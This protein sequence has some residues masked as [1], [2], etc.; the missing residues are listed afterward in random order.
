MSLLCQL[1]LHR[2]RAHST[3]L[4]LPLRFERCARC[5]AGRAH[6]GDGTVEWYSPADVRRLAPTALHSDDRTDTHG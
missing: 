6:Y 5:G 4:R 2:W 1:G 3:G